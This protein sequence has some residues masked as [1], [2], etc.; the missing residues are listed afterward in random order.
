MKSIVEFDYDK[1]MKKG[2]VIHCATE[3]QAK[4]LLTWADSKGLEW[5]NRYTYLE[6]I[7]W[8]EYKD[9]TCYNLLEGGYSSVSW[10]GRCR[11]SI[12]SYEEVLKD[13]S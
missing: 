4:N 6:K 2:V 5:R 12:I 11:Y 13:K 7:N 9:E 3:E 10:Y 1:I 8:R